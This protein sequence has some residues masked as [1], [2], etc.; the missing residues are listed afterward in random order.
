MGEYINPETGERMIEC[1]SCAEGGEHGVPAVRHSENPD[2]SGYDL[3]QECI[4][5]YNQRERI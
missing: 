2:W 1:D 5:E 4:E 3:C